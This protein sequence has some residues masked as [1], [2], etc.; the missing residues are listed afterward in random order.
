ML[1]E[2]YGDFICM[3]EPEIEALK[4]ENHLKVFGDS[5]LLKKG[6]TV[7]LDSK[8]GVKRPC[9]M[10]PTADC[11]RCGCTVPPMLYVMAE[12]GHIPTILNLAK[13][14]VK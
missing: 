14:F 9:V 4:P 5:C 7:S 11:D 2:K 8:G 3:T 10:G 6:G 12:K 1:K 13:T